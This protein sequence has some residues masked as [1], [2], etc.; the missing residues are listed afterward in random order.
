MILRAR[1]AHMG[2]Y[3]PSDNLDTNCIRPYKSSLAV[4]IGPGNGLVATAAFVAGAIYMLPITV[5]SQ[6][7]DSCILNKLKFLNHLRKQSHVEHVRT[8]QV[9]CN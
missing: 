8:T 6:Q 7:S 5:P 9:G 1:E 3:S 2:R 4:R